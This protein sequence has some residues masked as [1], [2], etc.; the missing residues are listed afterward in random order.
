MESEAK[1]NTISESYVAPRLYFDHIAVRNNRR[2]LEQ[3]DDVLYRKG[4]YPDYRK[5]DNNGNEIKKNKISY[6]EQ[7][8]KAKYYSKDNIAEKYLKLYE[9]Y[10]LKEQ[11]DPQHHKK[12]ANIRAVP[13]YKSDRRMMLDEIVAQE[14]LNFKNI[15]D[16]CFQKIEQVK[17][18]ISI[19]KKNSKTQQEKLMEKYGSHGS[20]P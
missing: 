12:I 3:D 17:S 9:K 18:K 6:F 19:D 16:E 10:V 7:Q 15:S 20:L 5:Y 11:D 2:N 1:S 13:L 8:A 14:G 4:R